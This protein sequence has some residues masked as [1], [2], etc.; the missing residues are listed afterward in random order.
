MINNDIQRILL[1]L[2]FNTTN[3]AIIEHILVL[4]IGL[5]SEQTKCI[6]NNTDDNINHNIKHNILEELIKYESPHTIFCSVITYSDLKWVTSQKT[7]NTT[8]RLFI[9]QI[10]HYHLQFKITFKGRKY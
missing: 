7:T 10:I 5:F 3:K 2:L 1:D 9:I 4:F 6:N 8:I